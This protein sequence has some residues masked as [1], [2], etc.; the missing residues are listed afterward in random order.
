[1]TTFGQAQE[2]DNEEIR[3]PVPF[4]TVNHG[5]KNTTEH[6]QFLTKR[7]DF[8]RLK[9]VTGNGKGI[10]VGVVDTG[11]DATHA[12]KGGDL[13]LYDGSNP[14]TYRVREAR[15]FTNSRSGWGDLNSH[16]THVAGHIGAKGDGRGIEGIASECDLY[17]AKGLGDGGFGSDS[18]ISN[19]INW[20]I[21]KDVDIINLSLGGG[22]S[23]RIETAVKRANQAGII[24]FAAMGNSGPSENTGGHPGTSKYSYAVTAVDY[25]KLIARFSSRSRLATSCGYGV[26]VMSCVR[27]GR[28]AALS[29]TSMA[30]PDQAGI[31]ALILSYAKK[32]GVS[33]KNTVDYF[34]LIKS[35]F[36]DKG[37][38]GWDTAYG[39]GFLDVW[40][41][42]RYID[43]NSDVVTDPVT[44]GDPANPYE[45]YFEAGKGV[46]NG[47]KF[48]LLKEK[49]SRSS[50]ECK[51]CN[52]FEELIQGP[53]FPQIIRKEIK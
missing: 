35:S 47:S 13:E 36:E 6:P 49:N 12:R 1:M 25:N 16:S 22:F 50:Q 20:L 46:F 26:N 37:P 27:N 29:G 14:T 41:V 42:L 2:V 52:I 3:I 53:S 45:N 40:G 18:Q 15:D 44:P 7:G 43:Q 51:E 10:K 31:C 23:Q 4:Y 17:I 24:V 11:L 28:Y 34:T 30:C 38:G 9:Q 21:E 48:I 39:F 8:R 5:I 32:K 19:A 33:I